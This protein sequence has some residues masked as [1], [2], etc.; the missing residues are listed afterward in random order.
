MSL[1]INNLKK[2]ITSFRF[3]VS[4][5]VIVLS[6]IIILTTYGPSSAS[7]GGVNLFILGNIQSNPI[8]TFVAPFI[9]AYI[10]IPIIF[11]GL[12]NNGLY[13]DSG[14]K[15]SKHVISCTIAGGLVFLLAFLIILVGCFIYNPSDGTIDYYPL[16][17]FKE[18]Y[19]YSNTL[20]VALF[21]LHSAIFGAIFTLFS[22]GIALT[23]KNKSMALVL[24]GIIYNCSHLVAGLIGKTII[25]SISAIVPYLTYEFGSLDLPLWKNLSDFCIYFFLSIALTFYG[26]LKLKKTSNISTECEGAQNEG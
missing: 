12:C 2:I 7:A 19:Y 17:L 6:T 24:P 14:K 8:M 9:P 18:T 20:Y 10:I 15:L 25:S 1:V 16:G 22:V 23:S 26:Y 21:I 11:N 4:V 5:G 13:H 3:W